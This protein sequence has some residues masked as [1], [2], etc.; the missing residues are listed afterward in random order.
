VCLA[1]YAYCNDS[2]IIGKQGDAT[3][4]GDISVVGF[5]NNPD[6]LRIMMWVIGDLDS[7]LN[8][9]HYYYSVFFFDSE[10]QE[11]SKGIGYVVLGYFSDNGLYSFFNNHRT[12]K[13]KSLSFE[14][15][16]ISTDELKHVAV[17]DGLNLEDLGLTPQQDRYVFYASAFSEYNQD[18]NSVYV[19]FEPDAPSGNWMDSLN[20]HARITLPVSPQWPA[21]MPSPTATP[22]SL[23]TAQTPTPTIQPTPTVTTSQSGSEWLIP[24]ELMISLALFGVGILLSIWVFTSRKGGTAK[25]EEQSADAP[26]ASAPVAATKMR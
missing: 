23:P 18:H 25:K 12:N 9:D 13:T 5:Y 11:L 10:S 4:N 22:S 6:G 24:R 26:P 21:P 1:D 7:A 20:Y 16:G 3:A 14:L 2:T 17:I 8:E 19:D 15:L